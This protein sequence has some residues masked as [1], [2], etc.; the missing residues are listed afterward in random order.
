MGQSSVLN[1]HPIL[2]SFVIQIASVLSEEMSHQDVTSVFTF[3]EEV[4]AHG[5]LLEQKLSII[6]CVASLGRTSIISNTRQPSFIH[7]KLKRIFHTMMGDQNWVV[8]NEVAII[9]SS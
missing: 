8:C 7:A 2:L 4:V 1:A 6:T 5:T 3:L 9:W